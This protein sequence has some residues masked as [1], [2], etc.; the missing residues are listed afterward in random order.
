MAAVETNTDKLMLSN[1]KLPKM[2]RIG[3]HITKEPGT[4]LDRYGTML[5]N[6]RENS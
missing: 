4:R 6:L 1:S 5:S 3:T 2:E